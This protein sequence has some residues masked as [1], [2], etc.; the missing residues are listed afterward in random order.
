V[1]FAA[2]STFGELPLNGIAGQVGIVSGEIDAALGV[3][4]ETTAGLAVAVEVGAAV[5]TDAGALAVADEDMAVAG[6]DVAGGATG[7]GVLGVT[8]EALGRVDA[9]GVPVPTSTIR[10]PG[11]VL[12]AASASARAV[13][14]SAHTYASRP[15]NTT[16]AVRCRAASVVRA[17]SV[18]SACIACAVEY[19]PTHMVTAR[20]AAS[21]VPPA[22]RR[23]DIEGS[24][25][26]LRDRVPTQRP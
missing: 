13:G 6:G 17:W 18:R 22:R 16:V 7:S 21:S 25:E 9:G 12:T 8:A 15:E 10:T 19:V 14:V 23:S 1:A 20:P 3:G 24:S 2:A 5:V 4:A 11:M 26:S